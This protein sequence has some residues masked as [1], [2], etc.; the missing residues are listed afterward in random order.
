MYVLKPIPESVADFEFD[1]LETSPF[2]RRHGYVM[3]FKIS[4][5][6]VELILKSRVFEEFEWDC[7]EHGNLYWKGKYK[8][9]FDPNTNTYSS[10]ALGASNLPLYTGR[11]Q[12]PMWFTPNDWDDPKVY[13]FKEEWGKSNRTQ[14]KVLIF[15]EEFEEAY[16]VE[17]L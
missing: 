4:K 7:Y 13:K 3:R 5:A 2:G 11:K 12:P 1:E 8:T 14:V 15:N 10:V 16:F 9:E 17:D 6:D